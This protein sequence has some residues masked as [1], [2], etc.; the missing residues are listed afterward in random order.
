MSM[1]VH[2]PFIIHDMDRDMDMDMDMGMDM[3]MCAESRVVDCV[4]DRH[5]PL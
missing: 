3:G 4:V 2:L 5:D 1:H